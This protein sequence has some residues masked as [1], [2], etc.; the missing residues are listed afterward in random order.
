MHFIES[1][2]VSLITLQ[3]LMDELD[4]IWEKTFEISKGWGVAIPI[5]L[6]DMRR[7]FSGLPRQYSS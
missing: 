3:N 5:P 1:T 6:V 7:S 4:L 2:D